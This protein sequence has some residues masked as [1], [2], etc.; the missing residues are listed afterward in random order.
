MRLTL[1]DPTN[2]VWNLSESFGTERVVLLALAHHA[3]PDGYCWPGLE[4]IAS[5]ARVGTRATQT[6]LAKLIEAEEL[7]VLR[8]RGRGHASL[9]RVVLGQEISSKS[10]DEPLA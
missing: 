5:M 6:A 8:G 7:G 9:Y 2:A 1:L 10:V 3:D 4:R